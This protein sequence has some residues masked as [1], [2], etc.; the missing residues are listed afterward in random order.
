MLAIEIAHTWGSGVA[1][2]I[3]GVV[4]GISNPIANTITKLATMNTIIAN[5]AIPIA[6]S[7][8]ILKLA[9]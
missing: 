8:P 2:S 3:G 7:H 5:T 4:P 1:G 6:A 9:L